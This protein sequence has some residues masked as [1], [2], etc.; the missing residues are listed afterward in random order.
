[1]RGMQGIDHSRRR[2]SRRARARAAVG[3]AALALAAT[4]PLALG[5]ASRP[6]PGTR[7]DMKVLLLSADGQETGFAAWKA[8]LDREG[9]P[10]DAKIADSESPFT[11]ATFAD[12]AANRAKYQAVILASGDLVRPVGTAPDIQYLTALSDAEWAAL[13]KFES[14]FGVRQ[15][16]DE[17]TP[18]PLHGMN[19]PVSLVPAEQGGQ[20][21]QLTATGLQAFPYLKGPV[22]IDA[23]S[24]GYQST[25]V[26]GADFQTLLTGPNSSSYLGV[27][28]HPDGREEMVMT[29]PG[30]QH[31]IHNA[32]LRH[33]MLNWVTRGVYLGYQR[34]YFEMQVD[35]VFLTD[36]RW[37][38]TTN[39]TP[40][41][42]ASPPDPCPVS[43]VL[44]TPADVDQAIA[45]QNQ[46]GLKLDMVF[47][48]FGGQSGTP[49][50]TSGLTGKFLASAGQFRWINHTYTHENL[51]TLSQAELEAEIATN[52]TFANTHS[53]PIDPTELVTGEHSGLH[54]PAMP[55]ALNAIG[56]KWIGADNSR[57][58]DQYA[59][60]GALT[61]PRH[62]SNVYY[63]VGTRAEQLDEYNHVYLAPPA[64]AC[65]AS[66][67]NTC[68][69]APATWEQY[70]ASERDIMFRHLVA[71]DP[72][73]H[74]AHQSNL[75]EDRTLY[76]VMDA[77]IGK[78]RTYYSTPLMQLTHAQ[79][80]AELKRQ[81]KWKADRDAG[82]VTAFIRDGKVYLDT[83][84]TL[85]VPLTG[86]TVGGLYGG[87][88]SGWRTVDGAETPVLDTS[89]PSATAAPTL[90][91]SAAPGGTLTTTTG[92][93]AATAPLGTAI[94]WQRCSA[95]GSDCATIA[96]QTGTTYAVQSGDLGTRIRSVV[97][98]G[99]WISSV[100]QA[101]ST[102]SAVVA[103]P[104]AGT[105][106]TG[107]T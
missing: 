42:V 100:S 103:T 68:L 74:Y 27:Y 5:V 92:T 63:N 47:N 49:A 18:G 34:D 83:T 61:V 66:P 20:V 24:A 29:V 35:D 86:T 15:I 6:E 93:W 71:N 59:I 2:R 28:T 23:G 7:I 52:I 14:T 11:D 64:G 25:P 1:M 106:G 54:N 53:L 4:A 36:D 12:Y 75:A 102:P 81:A 94:R 80:G 76:D 39:T 84:E 17:T 22:P 41:D 31:Q 87:Q 82:K 88:T 107:G 105:P 3:L 85:E 8:A 48:G 78:Y 13:A 26:A 56:I 46:N 32:L 96:G 89:D 21:G 73:P 104:P 62:P 99:N 79:I 60:G 90:T 55:A 57:E 101:A 51:D 44:M 37:D 91:G 16:S 40:C 45:W 30:N 72:R 50:T 38:V 67:T 70:V 58:P 77:T 98:A 95:A 65:V 97:L 43:P 10:Y 33:G 9:V 19:P 69:A